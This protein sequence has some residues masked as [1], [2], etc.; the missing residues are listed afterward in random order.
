MKS[1][2]KVM[3]VLLV[4]LTFGV[5]AQVPQKIAYQAVVRNA[6]GTVIANESVTLQVNFRKAATNGEVIYSELHNVTTTPQGLITVQ[7][8][9]GTVASGSF[10]DIPWNESIYLEM[11]VKR[12]TETEFISMGTSQIVSV[13]YAFLADSAL[14]AAS[15]LNGISSLG[16]LGNIAYS[17]GIAWAPTAQVSVMDST[18]IVSPKPDHDPEK[19]IFAVT[20]SQGQVVMAVYET[21]VRFNVEGSSTKGAKGGFAVGGLTNGKADVL[22]TPTYFQLEPT[23]A[24]F[25]FDQTAKGAKGGFAVGGLGGTKLSDTLNYMIIHPDSIRFAISSTLTKGAKGGFAV[26]GLTN[27]VKSTANNY[28]EVTPDST[29]VVNTMVSYSDMMVMGT[30][31]TNVGVPEPPLADID[32]I[33]YNTV[34]IGNQVWMAENL[35]T[36]KY[37]DGTPIDSMHFYSSS[38]PDSTVVFGNYYSDSVLAIYSGKNVCP[39]GWHVPNID[40]WQTLLTEVGGIDW[41]LN[42][43]LAFK[44]IVEPY[45]SLISGI[46]NWIP[47][48]YVIYTTNETG[49]SARGAGYTSWG[50]TN[51]SFP[52]LTGENAYFLIDSVTTQMVNIDGYSGGV[53][54]EEFSSGMAISIRCVKDK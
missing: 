34:R 40:E 41:S 42:P 18:V 26:G 47:N 53:T 2:R 15:A 50:A 45:D 7:L 5:T 17:T 27:A 39:L 37:S 9:A 20:N 35:R 11:L 1:Q 6:D 22:G 21:G 30:V 46:Y 23:Y 52:I 49:F 16:S 8:G 24:Q 43:T 54:I 29:Y 14:T 25:L 3:V 31:T 36:S 51:W 44:K 32:S 13:P 33:I 48:Q 12:T 10:A 28:F 4:L 38:Y 19:P